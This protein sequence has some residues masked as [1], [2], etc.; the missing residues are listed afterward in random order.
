VRSPWRGAEKK[1]LVR[2]GILGELVVGVME[3]ELSIGIGKLQ[4]V[5]P[6]VASNRVQQVTDEQVR[7]VVVG[8]VGGGG[9]QD[10]Q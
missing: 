2:R 3:I 7:F 4:R 10:G 5:G 9:G 8:G 6:T 1:V